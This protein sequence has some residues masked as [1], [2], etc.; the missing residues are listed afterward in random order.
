MHDIFAHASKLQSSKDGLV[1]MT[2]RGHQKLVGL[3]SHDRVPRPR[4]LSIAQRIKRRDNRWPYLEHEDTF[5]QTR[6]P[7]NAT[8]SNEV[9]VQ[10]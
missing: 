1:G 4:G 6:Q 10:V 5:D 2:M 8:V 3:P 9:H 7:D